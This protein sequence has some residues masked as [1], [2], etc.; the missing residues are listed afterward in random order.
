MVLL[1]LELHIVAMVPSRSELHI[2]LFSLL[3]WLKVPNTVY[4][5]LEW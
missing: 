5:V 4:K 3:E 1:R 2:F